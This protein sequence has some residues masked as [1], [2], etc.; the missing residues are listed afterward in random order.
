MLP[1][2]MG[3][4]LAS[5]RCSGS[6]GR[7]SVDT[8]PDTLDVARPVAIIPTGP[9]PTH[10]RDLLSRLTAHISRDQSVLGHSLLAVVLRIDV[11]TDREIS[12]AA[13]PFARC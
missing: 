8:R 13:L 1:T 11:Q 10:P 9:P 7:H 12:P 6:S 2:V 3:G 4:T 5:M